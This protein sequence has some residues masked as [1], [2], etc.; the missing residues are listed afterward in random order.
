[1]PRRFGHTKTAKPWERHRW[2]SRRRRKQLGTVREQRKGKG[3]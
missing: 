3:I 2:L 1:M